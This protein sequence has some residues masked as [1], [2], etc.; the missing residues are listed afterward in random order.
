MGQLMGLDAGQQIG[1]APD[2][3]KALAQ[4]GA[5][6]PF[7]GRIDI[8]LGNE[9]GA[10]QV[11]DLLGIDAVVLVFAAVNGLEIERVGQNEVQAGGLAGIGQP[12]PAEHAFAA[13][14]QVVA[15]RL[16]EL[17][18]ELEVVVSDVGVDEF[19][20]LGIHEADVHLVRMQVDSAV[21]LGGGGVVFHGP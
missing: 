12:V 1:A 3:V 8:G 11:G 9:I 5:Q 10:Q 14:G 4:Q 15:I 21:E 19:F 7:I 6:G 2:V 20:A 16:D 17:E 13:H 18:E